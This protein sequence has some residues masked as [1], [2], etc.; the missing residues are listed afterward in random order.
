LAL[1]KLKLEIHN[2]ILEE[3]L[4]IRTTTEELF[5]IPGV[6]FYHT[7]IS[8]IR[9]EARFLFQQVKKIGLYIFDA[10]RT[11]DEVS[12]LINSLGIQ[13]TGSNLIKLRILAKL[14]EYHN[15]RHT[16]HRKFFS[17][18]AQQLDKKIVIT[19]L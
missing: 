17:N 18:I 1:D 13:Q 4:V 9:P 6:N 8:P 10:T 15:K 12:L 2:E 14:S 5:S 16:N 3:M 19:D 7:H 11:I